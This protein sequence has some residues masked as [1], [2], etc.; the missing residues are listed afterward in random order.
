MSDVQASQLLVIALGAI[1]ITTQQ[2]VGKN[3]VGRLE[4]D[5]GCHDA[6]AALQ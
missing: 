1:A 2:G 5:C 4:S 3:H 6:L